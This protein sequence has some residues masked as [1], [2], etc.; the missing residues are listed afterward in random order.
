MY[1]CDICGFTSP[2]RDEMMFYDSNGLPV[3]W[4]EGEEWPAAVLCGLCDER[5]DIDEYLR[6]KKNHL[7]KNIREE[8]KR[9]LEK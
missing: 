7:N 9:W 5:I 1:K 6:N 2:Y 8:K 3:C 4:D